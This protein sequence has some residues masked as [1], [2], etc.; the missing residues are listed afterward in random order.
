MQFLQQK[1]TQ[2]FAI[3]SSL[4][5]EAQLIESLV[6]QSQS[7]NTPA[8]VFS[9][10]RKDLFEKLNREF[11][12]KKSPWILA[13]QFLED[14]FL[15]SF[16][17]DDSSCFECLPA[18]SMSGRNVDSIA[19]SSAAIWTPEARVTAA[20]FVLREAKAAS[21]QESAAHLHIVRINPTTGEINRVR[22]IRS[23]MCPACTSRAVL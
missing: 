1:C 12:V 7:C 17:G 6:S 15:M 21:V 10:Y 20:A 8:F 5:S 9:S 22:R 23:S 3:D 19:V 4:G 11:L 18:L 13:F 2:A 14:F 16:R